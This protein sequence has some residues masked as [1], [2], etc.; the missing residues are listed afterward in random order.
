M[1]APDLGINQAT[2]EL[3]IATFIDPTYVG[4]FANDTVEEA[5]AQMYITLKTL[6]HLLFGFGKLSKRQAAFLDKI[7]KGKELF[8]EEVFGKNGSIAFNGQTNSLKIVYY[9]NGDNKAGYIKTSAFVLTKQLTTGSDGEALPG[10]EML[11]NLRL[12]LEKQEVNGRLA[13]AVPVSGSK[14]ERKN[15]AASSQDI[16]SDNFSVLDMRYLTLQQENPS[17]KMEITDPSQIKQLIGV[18]LPADQKIIFNGKE[19][20]AKDLVTLYEMAVAQRVTIKYNSKANKVFGL[21]DVESEINK[22]KK[23]KKTTVNLA[24]F[25]KYE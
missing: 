8:P 9:N 25:A 12:S 17:N 6:R 13:S 19:W 24:D 4:K 2:T 22:S 1:I 15:I 11:H 20:P 3:D 21:E 23:A 10:K 16:S 14:G 5:N 18:E 7:E